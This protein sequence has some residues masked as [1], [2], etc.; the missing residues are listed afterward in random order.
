MNGNTLQLLDAAKAKAIA[1]YRQLG[2]LL[3]DGG[4]TVQSGYVECCRS[5]DR[6]NASL[7]ERDS[8]SYRN[9]SRQP[10]F[11]HSTSSDAD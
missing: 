4:R 6:Q 11:H 7:I 2:R 3:S 5:D 1:E 10:D 9:R 8:T